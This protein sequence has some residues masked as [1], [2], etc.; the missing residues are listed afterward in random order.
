[1]A[2]YRDFGKG[3]ARRYFVVLLAVD[4]LKDRA[5][6]HYIAQEIGC[7]RAEAQR[8]LQGLVNEFGVSFQRSEFAYL[9]DGWGVLKKTAI[10][11]LIKSDK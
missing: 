11:R 8:A 9:I 6:L 1:M 5:T 4:R 7:T 3:D 2:Q 10:A